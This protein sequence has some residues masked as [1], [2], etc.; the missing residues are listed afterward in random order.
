M[1]QAAQ[2]TALVSV[3]NLHKNYG[4][5][6]AVRGLS[7]DIF[8]GEV[9]GLLGPNGAGKTTTI[10]IIEGLRQ[11]D[12][13]SVRVCGLDPAQESMS[14]KER[15]GAQLQS[16][17]LPD[18]ML[19]LVTSGFFGLLFAMKLFRWE[20]KERISSRAKLWSAVFVVPF[21]VMG[22][23]MNTRA[24]PTAAWS[25]SYNAMD[26]DSTAGPKAKAAKLNLI[27]DFEGVQTSAELLSRWRVSTDSDTVNHSA[28]E[29]SLLTPGAE[30][31][32][33]AM[34]FAGR[35][36]PGPQNTPGYV[37]AR[38]EVKAPAN[39]KGLRGIEFQARGDSHVYQVAFQPPK[40]TQSG[41]SALPC[42][43]PAISFVPGETWQNLRVP[44]AWL[45]N[46]TE[47]ELADGPWILEISVT[48]PPGEFTLDVDEIRFY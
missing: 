25:R 21:L 6:A 39:S 36:A 38:R 16:T 31:S 12:G 15:I 35:L 28:A 42:P 19:V 14:L 29:V 47:H 18:K 46:P 24:N 13:G 8:Q 43:V 3:Q 48:G 17:V 20:K 23:W 37:S 32:S 7:F 44:I 4:D 33:H 40:V 5:L 1:N 22:V 45:A 9:F 11:P 26:E 30:G 41:C 2:K 34:R 27:D 10:E